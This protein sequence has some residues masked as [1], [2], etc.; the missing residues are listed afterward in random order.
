MEVKNVKRR[1]DV[2][3]LCVCMCAGARACLNTRG[4]AQNE[5]RLTFVFSSAAAAWACVSNISNLYFAQI[6]N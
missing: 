5:M 4:G 1:G 2:Y 6:E 3:P